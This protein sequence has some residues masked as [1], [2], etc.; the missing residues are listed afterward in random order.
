M[1]YVAATVLCLIGLFISKSAVAEDANGR[2]SIGA[3]IAYTD[4]ASTGKGVNIGFSESILYSGALTYYMGDYASCEVSV[5]YLQLDAEGSTNGTA[6]DFGELQQFPILLTA[7]YHLPIEEGR[8]SLYIGGGIGYY[9]N[10]F[11][12]SQVVT[13]SGGEIDTENGFAFHLSS[14]IELHIN[15]NAALSVDLKYIWNEADGAF[16]MVGLSEND[17]IDLNTVSIGIGFRVFF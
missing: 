5:G 16:N 11:N 8:V 9:I 12:T 1:K 4:I 6:F 3:S 13:L 15:R 7:R 17:D 14:G 10:N 2:F